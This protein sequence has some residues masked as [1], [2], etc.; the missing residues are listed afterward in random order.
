[1]IA[2]AYSKNIL[3][4]VDDAQS[5]RHLKLE[6]QDLDADFYCLSGYKFYAPA[7]VEILYGKEECIKKPPN[8][9]V[10]RGTIK[11]V[12]FNK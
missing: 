5:I 12:S 8:D 3:V 2:I 4:L 9:Q 10:G 6:V 7:G 1:M 11:T